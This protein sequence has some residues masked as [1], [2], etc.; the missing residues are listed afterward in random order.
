MDAM[1]GRDSEGIGANI[2]SA[3][4]ATVG[5]GMAFT[6]NEDNFRG[7]MAGHIAK[8]MGNT[9]D[10]K[11]IE[12][13][14]TGIDMRRIANPLQVSSSIAQNNDNIAF[15]RN[16]TST[17]DAARLTVSNAAT[18]SGINLDSVHNEIQSLKTGTT[19]RGAMIK[20][21]SSLAAKIG[22]N[23]NMDPERL[24]EVA[25]SFGGSSN[26]ML[27]ML[28]GQLEGFTNFQDIKKRVGK[29]GKRERILEEMLGKSFSGRTGVSR[30]MSGKDDYVSDDLRTSV[31]SGVSKQ[32]RAQ[33]HTQEDVDK[34]LQT[35]AV[36][37][38]S[39]ALLYGT[40]KGASA[41]K[42][43]DNLAETIVALSTRAPSVNGAGPSTNMPSKDGDITRK[44][45]EFT[46]ALDNATKYLQKMV[47]G[48]S[49]NNSATGGM[50][51]WLPGVS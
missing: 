23:D 19:D 7:A 30:F 5:Q 4:M 31:E 8:G 35:G 9:L 48:G 43:K 29:N 36:A 13:K 11:T 21:V 12:Q 33:G 6:G 27:Q 51:S 34:M 10:V 22:M 46:T 25:A 24:S 16:A 2:D 45:Q 41:E 38:M 20:T 32:L 1:F 49:M 17:A 37:R 40:R 39:D 28:G 18:Y 15:Q 50:L 42:Y 47:P 14:L 3:L 44:A 26:Q